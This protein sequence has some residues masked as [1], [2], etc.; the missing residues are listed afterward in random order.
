[1]NI[2]TFSEKKVS[3][4]DIWLV[5]VFSTDESVVLF[6][7]TRLF[8][9]I[10]MEWALYLSSAMNKMIHFKMLSIRISH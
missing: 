4:G 7:S 1:M 8:L 9:K 6:L 2:V 5:Q 3:K 10:A